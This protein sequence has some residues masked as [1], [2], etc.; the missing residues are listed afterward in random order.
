VQLALK[1]YTG[2]PE[3]EKRNWPT[4]FFLGCTVCV[5]GAAAVANKA[6]NL[7]DTFHTS[8]LTVF[9]KQV[10]FSCVCRRH[11]SSYVS[12]FGAEQRR[13]LASAQ[14]NGG[15]T[16]QGEPGRIPADGHGS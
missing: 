9:G 4:A 1:A 15:T 7:A 14:S 3:L 5:R 16:E 10:R 13:Y 8:A 11:Q 2:P 6:S 12:S